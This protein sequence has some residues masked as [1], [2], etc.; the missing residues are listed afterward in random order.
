[1]K[2]FLSR[3]SC[4]CIWIAFAIKLDVRGSYEI[5]L[6]FLG[7]VLDTRLNSGVS[8]AI[9]H[10][11]GKN[12][13][14]IDKLIISQLGFGNTS[15][16]SFKNL[17][18]ISYIPGALETSKQHNNFLMVSSVIQTSSNFSKFGFDFL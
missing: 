16:P 17:E 14:F 13:S 3:Y 6:V 15:V 9:L 10:L 11:S 1:M 5:G 4:V 18:D 8:L 12:D 7:S 2:P